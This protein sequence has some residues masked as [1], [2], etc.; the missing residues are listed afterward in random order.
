[1]V[2]DGDEMTEVVA[3]VG[4]TLGGEK[5][6]GEELFPRGDGGSVS[7]ELEKKGPRMGFAARPEGCM[8]KSGREKPIPAPPVKEGFAEKRDAGCLDVLWSRAV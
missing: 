3:G 8:N 1:M 7:Q 5:K 4:S 6:N 2:V